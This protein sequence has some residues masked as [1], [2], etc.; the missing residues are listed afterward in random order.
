MRNAFVV[1]ALV[2]SVSNAQG[3][4]AV[5]PGAA[6]PVRIVPS[7]ATI[8]VVFKLDPQLTTGLYMG[9]RWVSPPTYSAFQ[10]G[11]SVTVEARASGIDARGRP[12]KIN[13]RWIPADPEMVTVTP[14]EGNEVKITVRRAGESLLQVTSHG[15]SKS[16]AV[17]AV[18]QD[19]ILRVEIAQR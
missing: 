3:Q 14:G 15:L 16:L 13:A 7:P 19:E 18:R 2:V 4:G 8:R 9:E 5:V 12:A 17:K 11:T 6:A 1:L 10:L